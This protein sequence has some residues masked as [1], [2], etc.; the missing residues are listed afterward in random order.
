MA[1]EEVLN[2]GARNQTQSETTWMR[3]PVLTSL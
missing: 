2:P 1:P 3:V